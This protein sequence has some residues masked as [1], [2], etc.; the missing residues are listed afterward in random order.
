[1]DDYQSSSTVYFSNIWAESGLIPGHSAFCVAKL[2]VHHIV[3]T[4]AGIKSMSNQLEFFFLLLQSS[5]TEEEPLPPPPHQPAF[6][7]GARSDL[8]PL[9]I[10]GKWT[11]CQPS[12]ALIAFSFLSKKDEPF[13][14]PLL[15]FL[16]ASP[17]LLLVCSGV[18]SRRLS[19]MPPPRS[20]RYST[21]HGSGFLQIT[22]T[23]VQE[24]K[25]CSH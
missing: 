11:T 1:M 7:V 18:S 2:R 21:A 16:F 4:D 6:P 10:P 13:L 22:A 8:T 19:I 25:N 24:R 23:S 20:T 12:V 14:R 9:S 5:D 17:Q 15:H 3:R